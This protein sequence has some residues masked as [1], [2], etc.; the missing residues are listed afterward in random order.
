MMMWRK[1]VVALLA[2]AI[3]PEEVD[4]LARSLRP[5]GRAE[6]EGNAAPL[7]QLAVSEVQ[8][9]LDPR[10]ARIEG[11]LRLVVRNRESAPWYEIVLRA[12]P[13]AARGTSLRVDDVR[14]EGKRVAPRS[15]GSVIS[16]PAE[17]APGSSVA[18]SLSFHGQLR[19]LREGDDDPLAAADELLSQVAPGLF[20]G[21]PHVS[22]RGYGTFAVGPRGAALV[23]WYPQLAARAHGVWDRE[24]PG[25]IG[26]VATRPRRSRNNRTRKTAL[27]LTIRSSNNSSTLRVMVTGLPCP[28]I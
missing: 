16:V 14:V 27:P 15:H 13:N 21:K 28:C 24:E 20:S 23:D 3:A 8:A 19:R 26:D 11:Q 9:E 7:S 4:L 2:A 18:I 17:L 10:G 22:D 1:A 6:L 12:Y 25:S 5:E